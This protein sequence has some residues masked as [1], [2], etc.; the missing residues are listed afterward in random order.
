MECCFAKCECQ[1][2]IGSLYPTCIEGTTWLFR[3]AYSLKSKRYCKRLKVLCSEH[4]WDPKDM[5]AS[6]YAAAKEA[7]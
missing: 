7:P 2:S 5:K 1:L 3:D 6:S 4:S